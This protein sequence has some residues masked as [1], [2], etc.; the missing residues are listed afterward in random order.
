MKKN[1]TIKIYSFYFEFQKEF[2]EQKYLF[3]ES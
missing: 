1:L 3:N 2:T